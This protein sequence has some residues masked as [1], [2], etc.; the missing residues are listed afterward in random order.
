M[1][2]EYK[3]KIGARIHDLVRGDVS[4]LTEALKELGADIVQLTLP[5]FVDWNESPQNYPIEKLKA[6]KKAFFAAGT[7]IKVISCYINPL[8]DE[9]EKEQELFCKFVDYCKELGVAV[10]GTETGSVVN[11]LKDYELNLTEKNYERM[12]KCMEPLIAYANTNGIMVGVEAVACYPICSSAQFERLTRDFKDSDICAI[13]D[14][15]NLLNIR[16]YSRQEEIFEEFIRTNAKKIKVV[17]LKDFFLKEGRLTETSLFDGRLNVEYVIAKLLE[18][19]AEMN[20]IIE[21]CRSVPEYRSIVGRLR[22]IISKVSGGIE[23]CK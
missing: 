13:F 6:L 15:T 5:K 10:I 4:D 18:Y 17:H 9:V 2:K 3:I 14:A 12:K 7:E 8:A 19:G 11:D 21:N 1:T 16:N 22:Q 23:K 20:I